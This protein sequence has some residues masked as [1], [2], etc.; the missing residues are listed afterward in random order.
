M[1]GLS[2]LDHA[3]GFEEAKLIKDLNL[4]R[5][6]DPGLLVALVVKPQ[7]M[8]DAVHRHVSPVGMR[9]LV[10]LPGLARDDRRA[11]DE[12]AEHTAAVRHRA[13]TRKRQHVGGPI[14]AAGSAH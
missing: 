5:G 4:P 14:L 2:I 10:L 11:N 1:G 9:G 6:H 12:L 8:Q 7:E 3:Y 13:R